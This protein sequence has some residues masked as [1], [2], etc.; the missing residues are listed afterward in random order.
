MCSSLLP[1]TTVFI[2]ISDDD[3]IVIKKVEPWNSV[4][5]TV[6]IPKEAAEKLKLL[7]S[8]N[9]GAELRNMGIISLQM[10]GRPPSSKYSDRFLSR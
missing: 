7:A 10:E 2:F 8:Q 9:D 5:V 4:K 3:H 6:N 1:N